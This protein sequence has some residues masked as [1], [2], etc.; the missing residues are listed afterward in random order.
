MRLL[1]A[2]LVEGEPLPLSGTRG[3]QLLQDDAAPGHAA[4]RFE[5]IE[6][7]DEVNLSEISPRDDEEGVDNHLDCE[8]P[9]GEIG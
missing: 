7:L 8:V 1:N 5:C 6:G 4:Q 3:V 9:Q 2:V